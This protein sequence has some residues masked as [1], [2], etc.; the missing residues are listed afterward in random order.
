MDFGT[1]VGSAR[2]FGYQLVGISNMNCS[3]CVCVGGGVL[4]WAK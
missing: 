4:T 3:T 1:H 2:A